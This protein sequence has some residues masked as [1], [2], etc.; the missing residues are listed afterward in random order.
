M[1]IDQTPQLQ[2]PHHGHHPYCAPGDRAEPVWLIRYDDRNMRELTFTGPD[3]EERARTRYRELS[4]NWNVTLYAPALAEP[5]QITGGELWDD[6]FALLKGDVPKELTEAV[7]DALA[8]RLS[9]YEVLGAP[10]TAA[11]LSDPVNPA[12]LSQAL[13]VL[14]YMAKADKGIRYSAGPMQS[15]LFEAGGRNASNAQFIFDHAEALWR[16]LERLSVSPDL[17]E[18]QEDVLSH[19]GS[20]RRA[21]ELAI[22]NAP[23]PTEDMDDK[24]YWRHELTAFDRVYQTF[25]VG[26]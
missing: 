20:W 12:F 22:E 10:I 19:R 3:A 11:Q 24:A 13:G 9:R 15:P 17:R 21:L 5:P 1:T 8:A 16:L 26:P 4:V 14:R 2:A 7:L 23:E 25:G 18:A 6:L